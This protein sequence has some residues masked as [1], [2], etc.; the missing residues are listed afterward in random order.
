MS[1]TWRK[2]VKFWKNRFLTLEKWPS[3]QN[4]G[5]WPILACFMVKDKYLYYEGHTLVEAIPLNRSLT[6]GP[7]FYRFSIFFNFWAFPPV[8]G[9]NPLFFTY[10]PPSL[11]V[12]LRFHVFP[13]FFT[14]Y[15]YLFPFSPVCRDFWPLQHIACL[16]PFC[17]VLLPFC[18]VF[19]SLPQLLAINRHYNSPLPSPFSIISLS[20]HGFPIIFR[21]VSV[22]VP[23]SDD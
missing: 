15:P 18:R 1:Q 12:P 7:V 2:V 22:F 3:P 8:F 14:V 16:F 21:F 11:Y 10:F 4:F 20:F 9:H 13:P 6:I 5:T 23:F 17:S 19:Y